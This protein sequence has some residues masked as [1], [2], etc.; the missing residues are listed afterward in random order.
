M[1]DFQNS[2]D[3]MA[4]LVRT[5]DPVSLVGYAPR[6][7]SKDLAELIKS[8][9]PDKVEVIVQ[10]VNPK[11]PVQYRVLCKLKSPWPPGFKPCS[12]DQFKTLASITD[13]RFPIAI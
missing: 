12:G 3:A 2:Y 7:Y 13:D 9:A 1:Q 11:A 10:K 8:N 6:Y 4:L 5:G